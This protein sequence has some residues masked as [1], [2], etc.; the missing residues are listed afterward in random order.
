M[1]QSTKVN[2]KQ[3]DTWT[4][5]TRNFL[6]LSFLL[7]IAV[8]DST[9]KNYL[10]S[11]FTTSLLLYFFTSLLLYFFTSLLLLLIFKVHSQDNIS[12]YL[13][14]MEYNHIPLIVTELSYIWNFFIN[15]SIVLSHEWQLFMQ[16]IGM[17]KILNDNPS[18]TAEIFY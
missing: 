15:Q 3:L 8:V 7:N 1:K 9:F 6:F 13:F 18:L 17:R 16:K 12:S 14:V 2:I 11:K 4:S 10:A 5:S